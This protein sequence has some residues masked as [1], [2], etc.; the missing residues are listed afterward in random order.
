MRTSATNFLDAVDHVG[1]ALCVEVKT[2]SIFGDRSVA[3]RKAVLREA[4][5]TERAVVSSAH[6]RLGGAQQ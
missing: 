4:C 1:P 3:E 2:A 6:A 5:A